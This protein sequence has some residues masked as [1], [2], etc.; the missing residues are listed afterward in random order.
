MGLFLCLYIAKVWQE[1]QKP[2]K[3]VLRLIQAFLC[4]YGALLY[5]TPTTPALGLPARPFFCDSLK[6][7][8]V[9]PVGRSFPG[10]YMF[11]WIKYINGLHKYVYLLY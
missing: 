5:P 2:I 10:I 9:A 7:Q 6:I 1:T 4:V 11:S 8:W 3:G